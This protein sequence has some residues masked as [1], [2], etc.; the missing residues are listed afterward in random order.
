VRRIQPSAAASQSGQKRRGNCQGR[1]H[2]NPLTRAAL[3]AYADAQVS[4]A[5]KDSVTVIVVGVL[6]ALMPKGRR[7]D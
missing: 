7:H 4:A 2:M 5:I 3:D 1:R 6:L